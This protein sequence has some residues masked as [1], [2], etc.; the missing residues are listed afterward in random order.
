MIL[1]NTVYHK[2]FICMIWINIWNFIHSLISYDSYYV[3]PQKI[4][5]KFPDEFVVT[6][7]ISL[8]PCLFLLT[9]DLYLDSI[10][11]EYSE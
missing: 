3:D 1:L 11:L 6:H 8:H 4:P 7:A 9:C 2:L 10:L 5:G